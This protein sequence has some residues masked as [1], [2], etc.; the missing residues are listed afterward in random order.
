MKF[1]IAAIFEQV[2]NFYSKLPLA[3][4]LALPLLIAGTMALMVFVSRWA[5]RPDYQVLFSNLEEQDASAIVQYLK[6]RKLGYQLRN[7]GKTI[8]VT[9]P[10]LVHE[11]RLELA[12]AGL[13]RGGN[14]GFELWNETKLGQT[15]FGEM[16]NYVRSL[17]GEL[18]RTIQAIDSVAGVRVH[19]TNP[20][21]SVFAKRD[22]PPTA[23]VLLKLKAGAE[24]GKRQVKGIA[25]LVANSVERLTPENVTI[26]NE[27][28][29]LLNETHDEEQTG[30][31]DLTRLE[32]QK[33]VE[34][35]YVKDIESMLHEV[36]GYGRAVARVTAEMDFSKFEKEEELYDPAG[37]VTRSERSS[38]ETTGLT[39]QGG[40]PGVVSNLT[41]DPGLLTPPDSSKNSN[42]RNENVKNYEISRAVSR[43]VSAPGKIARL[44]VAVLVD[45]HHVSVPTGETNENGEAVTAL[46]YKPLSAEMTRKIEAL[47]KQTVGFDEARGDVVTVENIP[48]AE[49][50]ENLAEVLKDARRSDII[51]TVVAWIA[52]I[53][54]IFLFYII[55]VRPL[56]K[57]LVTPSE[58]EIDL[59]RLLPAGIEELEAELEAERSKLSIMPDRQPAVD[60]EE[61][62]TLLSENSRM[63]KE[64]PQQAAL[65]IRYWLN[66]GRM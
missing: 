42:V 23:S 33:K 36:L 11:L 44:S 37:T 53:I 30:G 14:V 24:L 46:H 18:E 21:R 3:Q 28:G 16:L 7:D 25:H 65:L 5:T 17:Q 13:P 12:G 2:V 64:N 32:Y 41:N 50:E 29:D 48:F 6:E 66:D 61:L 1:D 15:A 58:S 45:G 49:P 59:S 27:K 26:L 38:A 39:A 60:I 10:E 52:P 4:K 62:E 40:V 43:T 34:N 47:V 63:V 56:V 8:D 31:A 54:L 9:P 20:K 19:I 51:N 57:F 55:V 35:S 22:A